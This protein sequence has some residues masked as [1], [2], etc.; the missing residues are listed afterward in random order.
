M[1]KTNIFNG[2]KEKNG[3][4]GTEPNMLSGSSLPSRVA[5]KKA[6]AP[7]ATIQERQRL[8]LEKHV[9]NRDSSSDCHDENESKE[10][11]G[12]ESNE[13]ITP[14]APYK[15]WTREEEQALLEL[16]E[17]PPECNDDWNKLAKHPQ[18]LNRTTQQIQNKWYYIQRNGLKKRKHVNYDETDR[19]AQGDK[20]IRNWKRIQERQRP[21][22]KHVSNRDTSSDCHDENESK[23]ASINEW[24]EKMRLRAPYQNWT[25]EE[26]QALLELQ[27]HSTLCD[28]WNAHAMHPDLMNRTTRQIQNKWYYIQRQ[29][30][31]DK[32]KN[33]S[34]DDTDRAQDEKR[35]NHSPPWTKEEEQAILKLQNNSACRDKWDIIAKDP[36]L[37]GRTVHQIKV[38]CMTICKVGAINTHNTS[39]HRKSDK[40]STHRRKRRTPWT[41]EEEQPLIDLLK[42]TSRTGRRINWE[43]ISKNP[44]LS[45]RTTTQ[46]K[47]KWK[48]MKKC[49]PIVRG[50]SSARVLDFC[51]G[52]E[53]GTVFQKPIRVA[54]AFPG[55][56]ENGCDNTLRTDAKQEATKNNVRAVSKGA[57]ASVALAAQCDTTDAA[58]IHNEENAQEFDRKRFHSKGLLGRSE[59]DKSCCADIGA[60]EHHGPNSSA[61]NAVPLATKRRSYMMVSGSNTPFMHKDGLGAAARSSPLTSSYRKR[62]VAIPSMIRHQVPQG[63]EC[64]VALTPPAS[65]LMAS[66]YYTKWASLNPKKNEEVFNGIVSWPLFDDFAQNQQN[67]SRET[68]SDK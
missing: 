52:A 41:K 36:E 4:E 47:D 44:F 32:L 3:K 59:R 57:S 51:K 17:H 30:G 61:D 21:G 1:S 62:L 5:V 20:R 16:Q 8:I 14:R 49:G 45:C 63:S 54:E 39:I 60:S 64:R 27:K 18:L 46:I 9:S 25:K 65:R 56:P 66:T 58:G 7:I 53:P 28:D 26:E 43:D 34:Y 40:T 67:A 35:K 37:A 6:Q 55:R 24:D 2:G 29:G 15:N 10:A 31:I 12:N 11:S 50:I 38:K 48:Y 23:E 68:R 22:E 13:R 33:T 42:Q 19:G